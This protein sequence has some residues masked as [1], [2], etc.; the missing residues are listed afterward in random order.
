MRVGLYAGGKQRLINVHRLVLLAFVG[1]CPPGMECRHLDGCRTNNVLTNICWGTKEENHE[2]RRRHGTDIAGEKN[3]SAVLNEEK[4]I[5]M[6]RMREAGS[7]LKE[8]AALFDVSDS[9]VSVIC[10]RQAWKHIP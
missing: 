9:L 4:V 7:P 2:D 8:L 5:L 6:R 3:S 10:L 1:P